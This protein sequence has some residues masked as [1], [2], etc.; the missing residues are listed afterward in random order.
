LST[1]RQSITSPPANRGDLDVDLL[2]SSLE[3]KHIDVVVS[4]SIAAVESVRFIRSLRRL[5]A[6]ITPWLTEGGSQFV[7]PLALEWAAAADCRL[8][9]SGTKT[10]ISTSD[11]V[12]VAPASANTISKISLGVTD[13]PA[14]ALISS[15]LGLGK[16]VF[17]LPTMHKSLSEAPIQKKHTKALQ[18]YK[19]IFILASRDEEGKKKF[20]VPETLADEVSH[21]LLK[22]YRPSDPILVTMGTTRGYID[23]VRYLS[24]YSTGSTGTA[25]AHEL[26]RQGYNTVVVAGP[27]ENLPR[28]YSSLERVLTT[29]D[30]YKACSEYSMKKLLGAVFVASVLDYEPLE[31][32]KGKIPSNQKT[33]SIELTPTK[34]IIALFKEKKIP[35]IAFKLEVGAS[36]KALLEKAHKYIEDYGLTALF[37]NNLSDASATKRSVLLVIPA[38]K[39]ST[40][41]IRLEGNQAIA[42]EIVDLIG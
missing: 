26:Y 18:E 20:P 10:H 7:T 13:T 35:K 39:K 24:N 22:T 31:R 30:M 12:V 17:L 6:T 21:A 36:E 29:S 9:F 15:A 41:K 34:K 14:L 40:T 3:G 4:G 16:P 23:D 25:V 11:A 33:M 38:T 37:A 42:T 19:N 28:S 32:L 2:S 1:R 8:A 27:A 5:G